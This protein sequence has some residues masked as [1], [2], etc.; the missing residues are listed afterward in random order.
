MSH[1]FRKWRN[2]RVVTALIYLR[3]MRAYRHQHRTMLCNFSSNSPDAATH[4][5]SRRGIVALFKEDSKAERARVC[6]CVCRANS[7]SSY[8]FSIAGPAARLSIVNWGAHRR[9]PAWVCVWLYRRGPLPCSE[10]R[11]IRKKNIFIIRAFL[12]FSFFVWFLVTMGSHGA[13]RVI[14][15]V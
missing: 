8:Q 7:A 5:P 3:V 11:V 12:L 15:P 13:I 14:Y 4:A 9:M 1:W 6:V 2:A 10:R